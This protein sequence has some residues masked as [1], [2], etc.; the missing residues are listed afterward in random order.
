MKNQ[1]WNNALHILAGI[2]LGYLLFSCKSNKSGCDA[3]S[4]TKH[5]YC[6]EGYVAYKGDTC[7]ATAYV[8]EYKATKD[9][10]YYTNSNGNKRTLIS[11]Y[12]IYENKSRK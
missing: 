6:I 8:N 5:K 2:T 1:I 9:S 12:K 3:Y 7:K 10:V 4:S 11:P